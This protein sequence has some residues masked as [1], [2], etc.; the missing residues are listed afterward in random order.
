MWCIETSA[1]N[2][3][4]L[5]GIEYPTSQIVLFDLADETN[6]LI[7]RNT[8]GDPGN[9]YSKSPDISDN[10]RYVV[11]DSLANNLDFSDIN[12][13]IDVFYVDLES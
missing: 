2:M 3:E 11:F 1:V 10:G 12:D 6:R 8:F 5:Y 13:S 4:A 9:G 7:S